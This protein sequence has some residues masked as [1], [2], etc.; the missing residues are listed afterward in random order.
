MDVCPGGGDRVE[1]AV[2]CDVETGWV[3][4]CG[5]GRGKD[6][7]E[8]GYHDISKLGEERVYRVPI[9]K[10]CDCRI[11]VGNDLSKGACSTQRLVVEFVQVQCVEDGKH[12]HF[13]GLC[14]VVRRPSALFEGVGK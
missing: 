12:T 10:V 7:H 1:S 3:A 5:G 9:C 4:Q 8:G 2:G 13:V 11:V 6:C 14:V